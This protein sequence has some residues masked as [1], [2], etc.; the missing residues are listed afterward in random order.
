MTVEQQFDWAFDRDDPPRPEDVDRARY[1]T[2]IIPAD[3]QTLLDIGCGT[4]LVTR[5]VSQSRGA[6]GPRDVCGLEL[7]SVGVQRMQAIGLRC[8]KGSIGEV[9]FPDGSFDLVMANEVF[10]HLDDGLY[11]VARRELARV[12]RRYIL[13]TVPNRDHLPTLTQICPT[14]GADTVPWG[15]L[16]SFREADLSH[17]FEGF[18]PIC[19]EAFGPAVPDGDRWLTQLLRL[20]RRL[21]HPL[22]GGMRCVACGYINSSPPQSRPSVSDLVRHPIRSFWYAVDFAAARGAPTCP[23]WLLALYRRS[24]G[25]AGPREASH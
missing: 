6:A 11:A 9:P 23:R 16:H 10:E 12:A 15:H 22:K 13:V 18:E 5:A 17:L 4:G 25:V 3:A 7:S 8:E 14:C 2:A 24:G 19:I 1:M 20:P 21:H